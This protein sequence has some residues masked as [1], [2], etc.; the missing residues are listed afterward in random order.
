MKNRLFLLFVTC[1]LQ[2]LNACQMSP[3]VPPTSQD[4]SIA[5]KSTKEF[6]RILVIQ[7]QI[8]AQ[9]QNALRDV[10]PS[11]KAKYQSVR[12]KY[13]TQFDLISTSSAK[14]RAVLMSVIDEVMASVKDL[15][16]KRDEQMSK[17]YTSLRNKYKVS[18][19]E[20]LK[21]LSYSSNRGA[22]LDCEGQARAAGDQAAG[23]A[24]EM[25]WGLGA[26]NFIA[27]YVYNSTLDNCLGG[28]SAMC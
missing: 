10:S 12:S 25:G 19:K 7:N 18:D 9:V 23:L 15:C 20:I 11:L 26:A 6:A 5:A 8:D 27:D 22:R 4:I 28:G 17:L 21:A 13:E 24:L 2:V 1:F 14:D 16:Q 3:D